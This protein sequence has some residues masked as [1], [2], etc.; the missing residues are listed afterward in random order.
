MLTQTSLNRG[1]LFCFVFSGES[2]FLICVAHIVLF[3][4]LDY[5]IHCIHCIDTWGPSLIGEG[6]PH[7]RSPQKSNESNYQY[8]RS[9]PAKERGGHADICLGFVVTGLPPSPAK[10]NLCPFASCELSVSMSQYVWWQE[11]RRGSVKN[12]RKLKK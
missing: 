2:G 10:H 3:W 5:S 7:K 11:K 6:F 1:Q 4:W 9:H 12:Y 8:L